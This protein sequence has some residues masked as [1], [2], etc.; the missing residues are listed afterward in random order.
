MDAMKSKVESQPNYEAAYEAND[1]IVLLTMIRNVSY[2]FESQKHLPL[3]IFEA[4]WHYFN[5]KQGRHE[6]AESLLEG[7][8]NQKGVLKQVGAVI[9]PTN[10]SVCA[11]DHQ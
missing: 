11:A 4:K 7:L 9:G 1:G 5:M 6:S 10:T 3:A 8:Q 2:S